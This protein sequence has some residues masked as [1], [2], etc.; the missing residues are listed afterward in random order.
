LFSI[1]PYT[2]ESQ[3]LLAPMA[4][5]TDLPFRKI[6]RNYGAGLTTSEMLTSDTKLWHSSK[7]HNR[8]AFEGE[9]APISV[10]IAGSEP[11][12]MANAARQ[13][14]DRGAQIIDINMG[15]PAKKVC[16]KLAG[17]ALMRDEAL[18]SNI[19]DQVVAAVDVPVTLKM[20]TGW[21][22]ENKNALSIAK[23][24]QSAGIQALTIHG[25]TRSCRFKGIAE[26]DT[27]AEVCANL[28][29]PII[30][31]GDIDNSEKARQVLKSTG[32]DAVMV[33]RAAYGNP[34]IFTEIAKSLGNKTLA[35]TPTNEIKKHTIEQ[36]FKE[37]YRFYGEGKGVRI[38]RKHFAWYSQSIGQS[39]NAVKAFNKLTCPLSQLELVDA[40]FDRP[41]YH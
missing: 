30:A 9:R 38:A 26:Y 18:V 6:C 3:V 34:W 28:S 41:I 36:H 5:V 20:R 10:Q 29:I 35:A 12:Q 1:G 23:I 16:R 7:S 40:L 15:C 8:L 33:G 32:A 21:D 24:A 25:R 2:I 37:L 13:C 17:S 4:G 14:V 27:I 31:N 11:E 22:T 39:N 19:L